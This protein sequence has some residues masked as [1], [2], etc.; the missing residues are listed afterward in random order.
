MQLECIIHIL[1][2][3]IG[4]I[5]FGLFYVHF[6]MYFISTYIPHIHK[7]NDFAVLR[8]YHIKKRQK[9]RDNPS[10]LRNEIAEMLAKHRPGRKIGF[11]EAESKSNLC[12]KKG[13]KR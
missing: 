8:K 2:F 11:W 4:S 12:L 1:Y 13:M 5:C 7:G 10:H 6:L 9:K 3:C